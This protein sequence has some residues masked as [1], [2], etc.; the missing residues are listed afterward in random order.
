MRGLWGRRR[1]LWGAAGG[2]GRRTPLRG[3]GVRSG[4]S[5]GDCGS[6]GSAGSAGSLRGVCGGES[7]AGEGGAVGMREDEV[8]KLR[9]VW[10]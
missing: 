6:A 7:A 3:G 4:G 9:R 10:F 2:T 8:E 5:G 1:G